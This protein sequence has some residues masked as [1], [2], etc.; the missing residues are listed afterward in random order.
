MIR[1]ILMAV[2]CGVLGSFVA[3]MVLHVIRADQPEINGQTRR[4]PRN[5][6][7][8]EARNRETERDHKTVITWTVIAAVAGFVYGL[9]SH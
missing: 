4:P 2:V 9:S 5:L 3:G 7:E 1:A 6:E 8:V